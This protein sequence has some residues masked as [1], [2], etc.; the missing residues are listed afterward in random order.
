MDSRASLQ[1]GV[2]FAGLLVAAARF[3][4]SWRDMSAHLPTGDPRVRRGW[5][6]GGGAALAVTAA[7][8]VHAAVATA[9]GAPLP[10]G[11][12]LGG[13]LALYAL[14]TALSVAAHRQ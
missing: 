11:A 6:L 14:G 8:A 1:I 9:G 10:S 4:W 7:L 5:R 12:R 3:A 2:V 13:V